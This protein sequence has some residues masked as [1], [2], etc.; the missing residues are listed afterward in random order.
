MSSWGVLSPLYTNSIWIS[1]IAS[2]VVGFHMDF[3]KAFSVSYPAPYSFFY[4]ALPS[5]HSLFCSVNIATKWLLRTAIPTD[6]WSAQ[7]SS[8]KMLL[9]VDAD[10]RRDPHV[11]SVHTVREHSVQNGMSLSNPF[12]HGSGICAEEGERWWDCRLA[13]WRT[14]FS[15][16]RADAHMNSRDLTTHTRPT[17]VDIRQNPQHG[18]GEVHTKSHP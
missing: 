12:S 6:Q 15:H 2:R 5:L 3:P 9:A 17:Q 13:P 4:L 8:E 1:L 7:L 18:E 10:Q 16:N 14:F 11:D